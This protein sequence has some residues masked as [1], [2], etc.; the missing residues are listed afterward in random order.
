M[1]AIGRVPTL[2][3]GSFITANILAICS[4]AMPVASQKVRIFAFD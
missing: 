3:G 2:L 1:K 4:G